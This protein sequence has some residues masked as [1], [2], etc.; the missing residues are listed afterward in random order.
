MSTVGFLDYLLMMVIGVMIIILC[1]IMIM[2]LLEIK[3]E[4]N[5][6]DEGK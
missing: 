1:L 5:E 3:K 2:T 6:K 4:I